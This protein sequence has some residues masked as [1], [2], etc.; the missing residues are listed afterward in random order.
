MGGE[1]T[2][3]G[4][5]DKAIGRGGNLG[6]LGGGKRFVYTIKLFYCFA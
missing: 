6:G 3:L 2:L 5:G 1:V 4:W